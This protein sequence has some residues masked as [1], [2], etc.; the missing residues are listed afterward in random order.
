MPG[1]T[2]DRVAHQCAKGRDGVG[3]AHSTAVLRRIACQIRYRCRRKRRHAARD[4]AV[5]DGYDDKSREIVDETEKVED[6]RREQTAWYHDTD[7]TVSSPRDSL[8]V[9]PGS[10]GKRS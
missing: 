10:N 7:T 6:D 4:E 2:S 9:S 8:V 3:H 5:R 1:R